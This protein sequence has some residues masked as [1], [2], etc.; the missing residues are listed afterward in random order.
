[1]VPASLVARRA[2]S[3]KCAGTVITASVTG[4]PRCRS[5]SS[6][7]R[8]RMIAE[9]SSGR[10]DSPLVV[11]NRHADSPMPRFAY[12]ATSSGSVAADR[13]A[14]VPTSVA[15][16]RNSTTDGVLLSPSRFGMISGTPRSL[17]RAAAEHVV[18]RSIPI[19]WPTADTSV[20]LFHSGNR[21]LRGFVTDHFPATFRPVG[22]G[23]SLRRTVGGEFSGTGRDG[24][25]VA[26]P[27][28]PAP[29]SPPRR[30]GEL[31]VP[32]GFPRHAVAAKYAVATRT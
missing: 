22:Q 31:P 2:P 32:Q 24:D 9:T 20:W 27:P 29:C 11:S 21:Q 5:A 7:R 13:A 14:V 17:I 10:N 12:R 26:G 19:R 1:M 30:G 4:P 6:L 18:P 16:A 28:R 8:L 25:R 23:K 3:S 15:P